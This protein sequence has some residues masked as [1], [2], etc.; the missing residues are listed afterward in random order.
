MLIIIKLLT[1]VYK[2]NAVKIKIVL[3]LL[4]EILLI[5]QYKPQVNF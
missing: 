1:Q 4:E 5:S 2:F 3:F